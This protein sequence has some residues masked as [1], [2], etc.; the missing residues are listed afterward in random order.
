VQPEQLKN[1]DARIVFEKLDQENLLENYATSH[2]GQGTGDFNRFGRYW[3]EVLVTSDDWEYG[4]STVRETMDYSGRI[5]AVFWQK[6]NG[7][8]VQMA[9][10]QKHR[11][12]NIHYRGADAWGKRGISIS[13]MGELRSTIYTGQIFDGNCATIIPKD[14]SNFAA[15]WALCSSPDFNSRIRKVDQKINV[16]NKTLLKL[17]FDKDHWNQIV[18]SKYPCDIPKAYSN[19]PTQ[20]IF[21]GH[22]CGSVI[23]HE[24]YKKTAMGELRKDDTVLQTALARLLGYQWPAESDANMELAEEQR[25]WV[26]AC[27][28][29]NAL[30]D[31]DGIACIPAIRGEKPAAD[32]LEAMLQAS[33]GDAWNINVLN[34]L[35]ASVKASSLDAW[36]RDKFFDQHSKMFGH[37]P[38]IWQVWDGLKDGFSALVNY[39]KLDADNLDRLIYTYLGDWI[40]SQE[41]GVKDGVDGADIR[42][43]AAQNLKAELEAIKQGEAA[44]DG[45]AGYDI[46]VRWKP[47]HEQPMGWNPDLNDG[48]RLNIRPFLTAKD[49][50]KKGAGILRGKPNVHWKKDRG[51][52]VESAPWYNLGE[53]Y[54]EKLGSR[55]NEHHLTL[56][57]KQNARE[58]FI[59]A[60]ENQPSDSTVN[61]ELELS[62]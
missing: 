62:E 51:T 25:Q 8:L 54:G 41:Q 53:Q 15:I 49:M 57:D 5:H 37:R 33:Y 34:E 40:R 1:P 19:D 23:W 24:E 18:K 52:D 59:T 11:L 29:L 32:R 6:G 2:W 48:V 38:F 16:T 60:I 12:K 28:S 36:L 22:P 46:F 50:G 9:E 56:A 20:W 30:M 14:D 26:K 13:L 55:I 35:L 58:L 42:L 47:T 44:S 43:A 7:E 27:E 39:H 45:K 4:Q 61:I 21:H 10:E 3:W 31:D 17:P